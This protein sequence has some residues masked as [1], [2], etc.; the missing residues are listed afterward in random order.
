MI[1]LK[2]ANRIEDIQKIVIFAQLKNDQLLTIL[3][4]AKII[5]LKKDQILFSQEQKVDNFYIVLD[6]LIKLSRLNSIGSE[7]IIKI[8]EKGSLSDIFSDNFSLS[9]TAI[10]NTNLLTIPMDIFKNYAE[11]N[12]NLMHNI[13]LEISTQNDELVNQLSN[14]KIDDN[15]EK[16]GQFLLK[17]SLK[18]GK[19]NNE[20]DLEFSKSEIASYLGMRLE[21]FSRILHQLKIEEKFSV[22][23]NKIILAQEATLCPYCNKEISANCDLKNSNFCS[24]KDEV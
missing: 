8:I 1:D 3:K 16:I 12:Y 21:T 9:A 5:K 24:Q 23:I 22:K 20:I 18:K 2:I 13:L 14:L 15:K 19:K 7:A 10:K 11:K 17:N 6:G 4:D